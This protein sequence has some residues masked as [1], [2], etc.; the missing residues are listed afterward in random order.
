MSKTTRQQSLVKNTRIVEEVC[1]IYDLSLNPMNNGYQ[2][3]VEGLVD[4]YPV[5][6]RYCILQSGERGDWSDDHDLRQIMLKAIPDHMPHLVQKPAPNVRY[7]S[8]K[9]DP[10]WDG[11]KKVQVKRKSPTPILD[12]LWRFI[13]KITGK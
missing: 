12:I 8:D 3:R 1:N 6:G 2:L 10:A 4:F 5:N 7:A 11:V 13:N 9:P